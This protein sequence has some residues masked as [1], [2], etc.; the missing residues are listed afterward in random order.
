MAYT[1]TENQRRFKERMYA[2]GY[3]QMQVWVKREP[4]Q[5]RRRKTDRETFIRKLDRLTSGLAEADRSAL[6]MQLLKIA[7]AKKEVLKTKQQ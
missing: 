3:R 7:E 2:D 6:F 4:K 1:N 5:K